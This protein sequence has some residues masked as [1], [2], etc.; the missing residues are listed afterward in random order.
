MNE[1]TRWGL[2]QTNK[3]A[4]GSPPVNY[5][6]LW[7]PPSGICIIIDGLAT[8]KQ[9]KLSSVMHHCMTDGTVENFPAISSGK[10]DAKADDDRT[11]STL[12]AMQ[13]R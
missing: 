5:Y 11:E 3:S 8:S 6:V 10:D 4:Y 1:V 9:L 13:V 12:D 7:A 2:L